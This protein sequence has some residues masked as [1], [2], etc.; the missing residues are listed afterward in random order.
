VREVIKAA[1]SEALGRS[2]FL[3][4]ARTQPDYLASASTQDAFEY[5]DWVREK[6]AGS[7]IAQRLPDGLSAL[8]DIYEHLRE[9]WRS[10]EILRRPRSYR[11]L[12]GHVVRYL[13]WYLDPTQPPKPAIEP[14]VWALP[15]GFSAWFLLRNNEP[16]WGLLCLTL[17]LGLHWLGRTNP[18]RTGTRE[19]KHLHTTRLIINAAELYYYLREYYA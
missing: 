6:L 10:I 4:A 12:V 3:T 19:L 15:L 9:P 14:W 1:F 7:N 5:R 11:Q 2:P 8:P 16:V 13:D 17:L 18:H